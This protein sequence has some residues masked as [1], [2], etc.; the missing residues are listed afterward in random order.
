MLETKPQIK[1]RRFDGF[2]NVL[3]GLGVPGLDRTA[4]TVF[5]N[6]IGGGL[7]RF[8]SARQSVLDVAEIYSASGL[9]AKII[10]RPADDCVAQG[11]TIDNDID[12][13]IANEYDRLSVYQHLSDGLRWGR[14]FGGSAIMMIAKDGK[15]LTEPLNLDTLD[16]IEELRILDISQIR[17]TEQVYGDPSLSTYGKPEIYRITPPSGIHYDLHETRMIPVG[18]TPLPII[19]HEKRQL[20]WVGK[21]ALEGCVKSI[22]RYEQAME[23]ALRLLERKQQGIYAMEGLGEMF[24]QGDDDIITKRI[25]MIDLVRSNL[26]SIVIDKNDTYDIKNLDVGGIQ[27]LIQENMVAVSADS[28]IPVT[29]LFGKSSTGLN[30]TGMGD[31]ENYYSMVGRIQERNA[32]PVLE[33]L[34]SIL[35]MQREFRSKIPDDWRI[36][37]NPLWEPTQKEQSETS[38]RNEQAKQA[39]IGAIIQLINA[40]LILPEEAR[41]IILNEYFDDYDFSDNAFSQQQ[42]LD[43]ASDV[44]TGG[45]IEETDVTSPPGEG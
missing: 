12:E 19:M 31:L 36:K 29:I 1:K 6:G 4:S 42:E 5:G 20:Y 41:E 8:W 7:A 11:I 15:D 43:Y 44:G 17:T 33:R 39:G 22:S 35:W 9:A 34:T 45:T 2:M 18:T 32:R 10:D 38:L 37:F 23:W 21:S 40:S 30:A 27:Q 25:N 26:N 16:L 14:L 13:I 28:D 24:N 3:S